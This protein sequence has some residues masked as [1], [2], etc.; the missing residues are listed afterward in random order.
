MEAMNRLAWDAPIWAFCLS[1]FGGFFGTKSCLRGAV[2]GARIARGA[3]KCV[4]PCRS[5]FGESIRPGGVL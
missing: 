1:F 3:V 2:G 5:T 4:D